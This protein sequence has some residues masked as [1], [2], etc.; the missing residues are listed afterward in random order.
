MREKGSLGNSGKLS[1]MVRSRFAFPILHPPACG[2]SKSQL[3][4]YVSD[5]LLMVPEPNIAS[6]PSIC[7]TFKLKQ[8]CRDSGTNFTH[9][10]IVPRAS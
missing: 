7:H 5:I 3:H 8:L 10:E 4:L 1:L 2:R 9:I 6:T